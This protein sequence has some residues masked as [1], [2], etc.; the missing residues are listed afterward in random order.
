[1][2]K[3]LWF[4]LA[5]ALV[6]IVAAPEKE[7]F[8]SNSSLGEIL[9]NPTPTPPQVASV[10]S[11]SSAAP[12]QNEAQA[13]SEQYPNPPAPIQG[14]TCISGFIIDRYEQAAGS[15]WT[16][17][18]SSE[19]A[20]YSQQANSSGAF[21]FSGLQGGTWTVALQIPGQHPYCARPYT[22]ASFPVT[23]SGSGASDCA[24][25]RFKVETLAC[26]DVSKLDDGGH[27]GIA[28]KVGIPGWQMFAALD[29]ATRTEV[30][31]GKGQARFECMEPGDWV[32]EEEYQIG[33]IPTPGYPSQ[34]SILLE[35]PRT[36]GACESLTFINQ[37]IHEGC[38]RVHK[39]DSWDR[40]L[41]D[42]NVTLRREDGTWPSVAQRTDGAG[43]IIFDGLALG[44]WIVQEDVKDQWRA[45]GPA[46]YQVQVDEPGKC[47]DVVFR[48]EPLACIDG[49]KINH[50]E[51]G[52]W[53]W[54]IKV[55]NEVT[56]EEHT[57]VTDQGGYFKFTGLPL[58]T[59]KVS[60]VVQTGWEPVTPPEFD[61]Q[62]TRPF[63]CEY[64]RFK[65]KTNYACVDVFKTDSS[66]GSGLPG[67]EI[68]VQPAFGG[69]PVVNVTDGTG[70]VRFNGLMPGAYV[71]SERMQNGWIAVTPTSQPV[72]LEASGSCALVIFQNRQENTSA[73][74]DKEVTP[75]L[76]CTGEAAPAPPSAE[77][78]P[79]NPCRSTYLVRLGNTLYSIATKHG[80]SVAALKS[81]NGLTS[82]DISAGQSLCIP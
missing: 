72:T 7:V 6:A 79:A 56:D 20:S 59:W 80:V 37:Q 5:I 41:A 42:W 55:R 49:Y 12:E 24:P 60:E 61:L 4:I 44:P 68:T 8:S 69:T 9:S 29:G 74:C 22:L 51:Q 63:E 71:I 21:I 73:P 10:N 36:P 75:L 64:A 57:T 46:A 54:T 3:W 17:T 58:G 33:W 16:V 14:G 50:L 35:S 70:Y 43:Y 23:L 13:P 81:A 2:K 62:L 31:D 19:G 30:T 28:Q 40:P 18:V 32:I 53:G 66:D 48:N 1:M 65:N 77:P 76:P 27:L 38:I 45:V 26:L 25:V 47:V 52:L 39:V 78:P 67:W 34:Q 15:G 11:G 82:N